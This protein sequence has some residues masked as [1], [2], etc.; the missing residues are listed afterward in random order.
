MAKNDFRRVKKLG[1]YLKKERKRLILILLILIPVALAGAIQPLLVGQAISVLRGED[2]IPFFDNLS[3]ESSI[4]L[5]IVILFITVLLRLG[6]QGFQSYNIQAV[7]QRLTARIRNDLF[8]HSMSLSLR[9]HDKMPVGKLLTRLTSDV[10]A[11]SEVFGSGAV[12]VLADFVSLIVI[13]ITMILIEW[14]LGLL[15]LIIQ[16]PVTIFILWLQKRYRKQN[17]KVREELSQLNANFQENLQGL[18]VVQMFRRQSL[19]GQKFSKTG[20]NY[21]NAVN[22]TIFYDS[23]ISAFIEWVSL[24]AVAMVIS[25]GGYMVTAGAMGLGTLTTFILYS[26]RLFEPLRQLAERFTQIQGGLTAVERISEL[27]EK[28]IEI[29]DQV[30]QKVENKKLINSN[31]TVFGEVLFENVSFFYR[32]DEP[33]I[34]DLSFKIKAGEHVALV[35]PTGSG[36][37]TL[38]RLLCRLYEPQKG[39]IYIDGQNIRNISIQSL[40]KQLGV[41][42]Q[43]TFLFSGNVS[44]NLRLDSSIDN[45]RLKDICSEL[46]LDNLL[47]KLPNGLDTYIRERGGNLSSG[48]RQ[49]LSIARVAI[50]DP[51]VLIMDEATAFMDPSTEATLQRDLDRLLEKRTALVIAHRLATIESSDR[52][53]VMRKGRLIEQGTHEELRALGGLYSQLSEL[54]EKGLATI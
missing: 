18:E 15:L 40:R 8:S 7:G 45:Q 41:V 23:S 38:I 33:I 35:G 12:G 42:L 54:Q 49:L 50:R 20:S 5:I 30:D 48:E 34:N 16:I 9:F 47:R 6:L 51:K 29:Y 44:D 36:K 37:T 24:A 19:N 22:G 53:L 39:N 46:G 31:K 1:K 3:N 13:S 25:L 14:R 11:L 32:E 21:K 2:T 17:Y 26:Q 10:D 27:L 43:D 4:S 52:I 28:K